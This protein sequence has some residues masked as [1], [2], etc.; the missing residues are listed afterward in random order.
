M[1]AHQGGWDELLMVLV[2]ILIFAV[3]LVVANRR[4]N[5]LAEQAP[6]G[7]PGRRRPGRG[8]GSGRVARWC[9]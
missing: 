9:R 8:R 4:A 3:L 1:L 6:D 7:G 2:P 5:S